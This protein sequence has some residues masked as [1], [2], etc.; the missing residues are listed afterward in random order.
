MLDFILSVKFS[1]LFLAL[2]MLLSKANAQVAFDITHLDSS[3]GL[4]GGSVTSIVQDKQGFIWIGTKRGLN[5]YDGH[6]FTTF[7]TGLASKDISCLLADNKGD[8][9]I[10]TVGGGLARYHILSRFFET[11]THSP[12]RKSMV[13]NKMDNER[14]SAA[15]SRRFIVP[16]LVARKALKEGLYHN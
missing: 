12:N 16:I 15:T 4:S 10:G 14:K 2:F 1:A 9:W 7:E 11:F 6:T 3:V 8:I 5:R 13:T